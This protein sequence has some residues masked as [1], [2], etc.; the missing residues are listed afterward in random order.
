M[1]SRLQTAA[2]AHKRHKAH[3]M[4][5]SFAVWV[6]FH[7]HGYLKVGLSAGEFQERDYMTFEFAR[8]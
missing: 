7:G 3:F 1:D 5:A 8:R 4:F 6:F 2:K